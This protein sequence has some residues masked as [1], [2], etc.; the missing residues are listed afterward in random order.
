MA[1][2]LLLLILT[3]LLIAAA[4][5]PAPSAPARTVTVYAAASL[6]DAFNAV[7]PEFERSQPGVKVRMNFGASSMLKAQ[8]EQG[9]PADVFA[10]ADMPNMAP[11]AESRRVL[12][13]QTFAR[14]RLTLVVPASNPGRVRSAHD[15]DRRG[16]RVVI[17]GEA[18]PIG[19]Y[20]EQ[21]LQQ[22]SRQPGYGADWL[23]RVHANVLSRE[24]NVRSL[25][26]KVELGE[27]DAALV[28]E[29]DA[30]ST[31]RVRSIPLPPAANVDAAYPIAVVADSPNRGAAEA[32]VRFVLTGRGQATL[33]RFG[34][35]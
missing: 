35:R 22:L 20:S 4:A 28:Y 18:V 1:R 5:R 15:L 2:R 7:G 17:T 31:R 12:A 16:L 11:L 27:A 9:A 3:P 21:A 6:T 33:H 13:P 24:A 10:S 25:L 26:A 32:F 29:T 14:T 30:R 19:R 8:I 23:K 34:F